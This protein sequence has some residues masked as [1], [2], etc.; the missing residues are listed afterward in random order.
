MSA[1][2]K[3]PGSILGVEKAPLV[4]EDPERAKILEELRNL[5]GKKMAAKFKTVRQCFHYI[6]AEHKG[7][8]VRKDIHQLFKNMHLHQSIGRTDMSY[9]DHFFD[10]LNLDGNEE[11]DFHELQAFVGP[12]IHPGCPVFVSSADPGSGLSSHFQKGKFFPIERHDN[13][14]NMFATSY[15]G[16]SSDR[17]NPHVPTDLMPGYG[18]FVP[19][20]P[21]GQPRTHE[22]PDIP[23]FPNSRRGSGTSDCLMRSTT[24]PEYPTT[25]TYTPHDSMS[26]D[27]PR[28]NSIGECPTTGTCTTH[29]SMSLNAPRRNSIAAFTPRDS[30]P[31]ITPRRN[32][33]WAPHNQEHAMRRLNQAAMTVGSGFFSSPR[34]TSR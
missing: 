24:A 18:G 32:S 21:P 8:I 22:T 1:L 4:I 14:K 16:F 34:R 25:G 20:A 12:Y 11:I 26:L 17:K 10:L 7:S 30:K 19:R 28:R 9:A 3:A 5:I 31:C 27:A 2:A 13:V 23:M 29:D 33:G 6:D 15:D